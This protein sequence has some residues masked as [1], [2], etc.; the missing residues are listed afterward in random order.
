MMI[1]IVTGTENVL[2]ST[3]PLGFASRSCFL[4]VVCSLRYFGIHNVAKNV[5]TTEAYIEREGKNVSYLLIILI[6]VMN[7]GKENAATNRTKTKS[8]VC[9]QKFGL[10]QYSARTFDGCF[11]YVF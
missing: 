4:L 11:C 7:N 5:V 6:D 9:E 2:Y 10:V 3:S 8:M 1:P